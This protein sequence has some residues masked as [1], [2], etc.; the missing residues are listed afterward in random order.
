MV[1]AQIDVET[2]REAR[3]N[4]K[5][6]L[7]SRQQLFKEGALPG[8][9]VDESQ[10]AYSQA[11]GQYRAAEEHLKT[12]QS[13]SKEEQIKGAA[14]QVQSAKAHL[15]SQETQVAYSRITSPISGIVADRPLNAGEMANPGSPL[16]T[17]MDIS[18]VVARIEVPQAEASAVKVG[19]TA[20]LTQPDSKEEVEGKVTRGESRR[21]SQH[22]HRSSLDS[23][24]TILASASNRERRCTL[25][26]RPR[27]IRPRPWC[28]SPRYFRAKKEAPPF[29]P[30]RPI[31][32]LTSAP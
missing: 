4:A 27:S 12:L 26:S 6:I 29:S 32:S 5:K 1:K 24:S 3:D 7:D 14:A 9:Q 11:V 13:V 28:P 2:A 10:A 17:I 23:D 18:R 15:D 19:Q 21:R 30:S 8:R 31:R 22:H 20:T 25:R 16:I